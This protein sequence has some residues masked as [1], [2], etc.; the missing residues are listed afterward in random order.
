MTRRVLDAVLLEFEG[1]I[2][3][4]GVARREAMAYVLA[5]EGLRL[6]DEEY[7]EACAGQ[8]TT[9]AVRAAL[10]R[11][12]VTMDETGRE[13][14]A[15]RVDRAFSNH[16]GKG[17]VLVDG[18]REA[19]ERL[20]SRVRVGIVTRASRRDVEFILNLAQMEHIFACVV[21]T[22]DAYPPKPDAAPYRSAMRRLERRRPM[23]VDG[24]VV[25][26]EDS[27]G[28][29]RAARDA[30]L[31]CIAVGDLPMHV[32]IEADALITAITG[33]GHTEV[34]SLVARTGEHFG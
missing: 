14:L 23:P 30:G 9:E 32:A 34:E 8:P 15:L 1:V 27:L 21:G 4:T 19:V 29:I 28:G 7:R 17:V 20:A 18:A 24:I 26:L 31:R 25:A 13:L 22:E 5:E 33:L 3:D 6:S 12:G 11:C 16:V 10:E 2:A